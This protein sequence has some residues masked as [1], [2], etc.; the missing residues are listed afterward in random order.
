MFDKDYLEYKIRYCV[1]LLEI[2]DKKEYTGK[3]YSNI[4][5]LLVDCQKEL[6]DLE[7]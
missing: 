4:L 5:Q 6:K 7:K 3:L 2:A 1:S